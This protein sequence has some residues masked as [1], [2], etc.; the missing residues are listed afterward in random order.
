MVN[1]C[2]GAWKGGGQRWRNTVC[3]SFSKL[4][5]ELTHYG[6]GLL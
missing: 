5:E 6:L 4:K 3:H 2:A 1:G